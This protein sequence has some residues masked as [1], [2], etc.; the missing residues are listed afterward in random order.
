MAAPGSDGWVPVIR[1][2]S[3]VP[4]D[5]IL[6]LPEPVLPN[7]ALG[8]LLGLSKPTYFRADDFK[9]VR[10]GAFT[11]DE[12]RRSLSAAQFLRFRELWEVAEMKA[13]YDDFLSKMKGEIQ[14]QMEKLVPH[15]SI[16]VKK[17]D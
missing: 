10:N 8:R 6:R 16:K 1:G 3:Q 11:H 2:T 7:S 15:N 5:D 9:V 12:S 13:H 17:P 4:P 14:G